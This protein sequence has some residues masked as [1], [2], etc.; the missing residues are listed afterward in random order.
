MEYKILLFLI[1]FLI[2][3]TIFILLNN[4]LVIQENYHTFFL[5]F[6][7]VESNLLRDFYVNKDY[8]KNYF[9]H[10]MNYNKIYI[11]SSNNSFDFFNNFNK[12]LLAKTRIVKT[13]L[14]KLDDYNY[15]IKYL[16][17]YNDSITNIT[18][19]IYLKNKNNNI[20]LISNLNNIYLIPLTK[21]KY[22]LH[23]L[24][25]ISYKSKIGILNE[26]NT[27]FY[28]YEKIF[29]DLN[30]EYTKNNITVYKNKNDL[31]NAFSK[32]EV[33][34]ILLF[35]ELPNNDFDN[36]LNYDFNN[37]IIIL[38]FEINSNISN[39]FFKKNDFSKI[40]YFD[41]NKITQKYLPK[42]FGDYHYFNFKPYIKLLTI[43]E[44]LICNKN[45]KSSLINDIFSFLLE[46]R[47]TFRNT[48]FQINNIEPSHDLIKYIPFQSDVL[49]LFR[50]YGYITNV[51]S[52]NCKYF[53]GKKE[54]TPKLLHNNGLA[55]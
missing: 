14:I 12:K 54:C 32:D 23:N 29:Q 47:N 26:T 2:I 50:K 31:F 5:P 35:T 19:P 1:I 38:P 7:N 4:H 49:K 11:F 55:D 8:K 53:V 17:K 52:P 44:L 39:I 48:A 25:E 46:Y 9:K 33:E 16:S 42:K 37:E 20:K 10:K 13:N 22:N 40:T 3:L 34:I 18:L 24:R 30:I 41:L 21:L 28:Y 36:F 15:N 45:I 6:Y 27:I 51:D 43:Q